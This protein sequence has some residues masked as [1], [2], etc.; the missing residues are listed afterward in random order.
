MTPMFP[1]SPMTPTTRPTRVPPTRRLAQSTSVSRRVFSAGVLSSALAASVAACGGGGDDSAG[2]P[3]ADPTAPAVRGGTATLMLSLE[4]NGFDPAAVNPTGITYGTRMA[5]VF[6]VLVY[7]DQRTGEVRPQLAE[8]LTTPDGGTTW[9]LRL[10]PGVLFSD[11]TTLDS[12]AVRFNWARAADP[13]V[14]SPQ[15]RIAKDLR[16]AVTDPVTL[17]VSL[18]APNPH[19]DGVVARSLAFVGS[20]KA[21]AAD[22]AGFAANPVGAGPFVLAS[23]TRGSQMVFERN[24]RYWQPERP[25]LD[26]LVVRTALDERQQVETVA[27]GGADLL[28]ASAATQAGAARDAGLGVAETVTAGGLLIVF[29]TTRAPFDD[30]RARQA[31]AAALDT[32]DLVKTVYGRELP[33]STGLFPAGTLYAAPDARQPGQ[34]RARAQ[35]LLDELATAGQPL[36]FT[37]TAL[38]SPASRKTAEYIQSR[39]VTLKNV[40]MDIRA[41]DGPGYQ[42]GVIVNRDFQAS[43]FSVSFTDPEPALSELLRGGGP[44]NLGGWRDAE[45]DRALDEARTAVDAGVRAAAYARV[46]RI[47]AEQV[48]VWTYLDACSA[49]A[50]RRQITGITMFGDACLLPDRLGRTG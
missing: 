43:L 5:A 22:P 16:L 27:S 45:A 25:Y 40:Q 49:T 3:A 24:P 47:A 21:I 17:T 35:A 12:D 9:V 48:P 14:R 28:L 6:D 46:Q 18:P 38:N 42:S 8:S 7:A 36:R 1:T 26:R 23:W 32:S 31:F 10:R 4:A 19:F 33:G 15:F 34:D 44:A 29:N 37:F 11:G 50:Y 20:P 13:G 2:A 41:V 30:V 39:L